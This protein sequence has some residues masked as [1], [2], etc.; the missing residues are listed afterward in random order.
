MGL[1]PRLKC[2]SPTMAPVPSPGD[3]GVMNERGTPNGDGRHSRTATFL[4]RC[5]I[6][7]GI[8]LGIAG[9][10]LLLMPM[11]PGVGWGLIVSGLA[12]LV[13]GFE[14]GSDRQPT[15]ARIAARSG[16]RVCRRGRR[17]SDARVQTPAR[18]QRVTARANLPAQAAPRPPARHDPGP[19][20]GA[21]PPERPT[22][23]GDG[24]GRSRSTTAVVVAD[25]VVVALC[26]PPEKPYPYWRRTRL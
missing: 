15:Q 16:R 17:R 10:G 8:P 13:T 7:Y 21:A 9:A 5:V 24:S 4:F 18:G 22:P 25:G 3:P 26:R 11:S 19:R 20:A 6:R 14:A 2:S 23:I 12:L 1:S